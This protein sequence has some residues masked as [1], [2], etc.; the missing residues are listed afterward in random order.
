MGSTSGL[1]RFGAEKMNWKEGFIAALEQLYRGQVSVLVA[2][3][4]TIDLRYDVPAD[5]VWGSQERPA[6]VRVERIWWEEMIKHGLT[7]ERGA[8][9]F[10]DY[11]TEALSKASGG[12]P[13][14]VVLDGRP[15]Q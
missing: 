3:D 11:L 8:I 2:T 15:I 10:V 12:P 7:P 4:E 1:Q 13:G 5:S 14:I 9:E 6:V